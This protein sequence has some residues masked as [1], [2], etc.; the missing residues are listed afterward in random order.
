[1]ANMSAGDR[2]R[3]FIEATVKVVSEEGVA[4]ATTRRIAEVAEAPQA[5]MHYAFENKEHLFQA[6]L[7]HQLRNG[8]AIASEDV[9]PGM[10]LR[11]GAKAITRRY[12]KWIQQDP[13]LQLASYE[14]VLWAIRNPA[15]EHLAARTYSSWVESTS[16]LLGKT[17]V[18]TDP[19]VNLDDL[20]SLICAALDGHT[21]QWQSIG[22]NSFQR[23]T[24]MLLEVIDAWVLSKTEQ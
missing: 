1:V 6:V 16:Q 11:A 4:K 18:P 21:M 12:A 24:K 15:S 19:K 10:G 23:R 13:H 8:L 9:Q 14:L 7:E 5:S 22:D 17:V 3:Q 20:A 2:R